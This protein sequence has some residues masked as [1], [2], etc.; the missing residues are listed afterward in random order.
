MEISFVHLGAGAIM[1]LA[2]LIG[3]TL[4]AACVGKLQFQRCWPRNRVSWEFCP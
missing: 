4:G 2:E 1:R 3:T